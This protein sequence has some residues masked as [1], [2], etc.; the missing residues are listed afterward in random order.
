MVYGFPHSSSGFN[1][2]N[3]LCSDA[4]NLYY[5]APPWI[6]AL[7]LWSQDYLLVKAKVACSVT[8]ETT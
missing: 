3:P 5:P 8:L 1:Y 7:F 6:R 2:S 4:P